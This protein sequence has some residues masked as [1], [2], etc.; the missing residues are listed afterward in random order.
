[1]YDSISGV[2]VPRPELKITAKTERDISTGN[3]P[4]SYTFHNLQP[5]VKYLAQIAAVDRFHNISP[6]LSAELISGGSF[7]AL[8]VND[9]TLNPLLVHLNGVYVSWNVNNDVLDYITKFQVFADTQSFTDLTS[10]RLKYEGLGTTCQIPANSMLF[11]KLRAIDIIGRS[12]P[13]LSDSIDA[14]P[15]SSTSDTTVF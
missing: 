12:S 7:P 14:T 9:I 5:N 13:V 1:M 4:T 2:D 3:I 10:D 11:I 6:I 8:S 15:T